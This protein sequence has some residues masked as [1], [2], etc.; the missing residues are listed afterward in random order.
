M[1]WG[2]IKAGSCAS[3]VHRWDTE[4]RQLA[5][6]SGLTVVPTNELP[7]AGVVTCKGSVGLV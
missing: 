6:A 3:Q 4:S 2:L 1:Y 7:E 5:S